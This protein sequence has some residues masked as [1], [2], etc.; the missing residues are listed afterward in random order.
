MKKVSI[1]S[2][3]VLLV[4]MTGISFAQDMKVKLKQEVWATA[5]K[6]ML[7]KHETIQAQAEKAK[8]VYPD[9]VNCYSLF[10]MFMQLQYDGDICPPWPPWPPWPPP[11]WPPWW[12]E[13]V[14][15]WIE[16]TQPW[17]KLILSAEMEK[18]FTSEL[19]SRKEIVEYYKY[20]LEQSMKYAEM[21]E[22]TAEE[23]EAWNTSQENQV[24]MKADLLIQ[25]AF[26]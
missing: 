8:E 24:N 23:I 25:S 1:L 5:F 11:P 13:D 22:L 20:E 21:D 7:E 26:Q 19:S 2:A 10:S 4:F 3:I 16:K 12:F 6:Q 9:L 17:E 18:I 14:Q 15:S